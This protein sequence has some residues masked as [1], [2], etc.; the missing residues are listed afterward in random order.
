MN[1]PI[2]QNAQISKVKRIKWFKAFFTPKASA[3]K[4]VSERFSLRVKS[5]TTHF[6]DL[7]K[8]STKPQQTHLQT[9]HLH[10]NVCL[11][12]THSHWICFCSFESRAILIFLP[13]GVRRSRD[14]QN[15]RERGWRRVSTNERSLFSHLLVK[16]TAAMPEHVGVR[17]RAYVCAV[18]HAVWEP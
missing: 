7:T 10:T 14:A 6:T 15:E 3:L 11:I 13:L 2:L 1:A 18:R 9:L 5:I 16:G 17:G 4:T 12:S 8:A